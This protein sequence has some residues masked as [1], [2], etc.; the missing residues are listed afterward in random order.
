MPTKS[1]CG[2]QMTQPIP[3]IQVIRAAGR[4]GMVN[5]NC[6]QTIVAAYHFMSTIGV[7][8]IFG[9]ITIQAAQF[10]SSCL[11]MT[12]TISGNYAPSEI[13]RHAMKVGVLSLPHSPKIGKVYIAK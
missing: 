7:I 11:T 2:T 5:A 12:A 1:G 6:L 9:K 13:K 10:T 8:R 3:V 4:A